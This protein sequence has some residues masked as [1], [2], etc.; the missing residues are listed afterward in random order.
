[1]R[2]IMKIVFIVGLSFMLGYYIV[3]SGTIALA[4]MNGARRVVILTGVFGEAG[5]ECIVTVLSIPF[6]IFTAKT[7]LDMW[8]E[9]SKK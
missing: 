8:K 9:R 6:V 2:A 5:A 4:Y 3:A 7:S 1:M